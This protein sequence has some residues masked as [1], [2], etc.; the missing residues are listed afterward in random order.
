MSVIVSK[1][2]LFEVERELLFGDPMEFG[3]PLFCIAPES[4]QSIDVDSAAAEVLSMIDSQMPIS[5]EH[6]RVVPSEL[7]G[8]DNTASSDFLNCGIQQRLSTDIGDN[9]HLH[10]PLSLQN[11]EDGHFACGSSP[12]S[13]LS[14]ASEVGLIGFHL[15]VQQSW[16][17]EGNDCFSDQPTSTQH[18]RVAQSDLPRNASGRAL[19]FEQFNDPQPFDCRDA[20]L[21]EESACEIREA[22]AAALATVAP[23]H[24][25]IDLWMAAANTKASA[26]SPAISQ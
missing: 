1:L 21:A 23:S 14:S 17:I 2:H 7:I 25:A 13:S 3:Q 16:G 15:S 12:S 8:V 18:R 5:T 22:V 9:F 20:Q 10:N 24:D 4:L 26:R 6:Q 19:Q 11:A